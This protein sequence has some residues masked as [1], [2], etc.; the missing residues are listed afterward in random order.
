LKRNTIIRWEFDYMTDQ[1]NE[2]WRNGFEMG[3]K[4]ALRENDK[5]IK[6]GRAIIDVMYEIFETKKEDYY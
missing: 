1:E 5:A 6:L 3:L 2:I 4:S